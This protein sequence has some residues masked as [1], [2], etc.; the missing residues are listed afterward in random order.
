MNIQTTMPISEIYWVAG[1]YFAAGLLIGSMPNAKDRLLMMAVMI[2]MAVIVL[3]VG[4][5]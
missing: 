1:L 2:V 3:P 4:A 5:S